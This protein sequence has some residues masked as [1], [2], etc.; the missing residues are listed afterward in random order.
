MSAF[1]GIDLGTS[2]V[3]AV[4][5]GAAGIKAQAEA[6]LS[7]SQPEQGWFEQNPEDWVD[8]T[9]RALNALRET[10]GPAWSEVRAIGLS[11]QMHGAV[12]L[13]H[14]ER[15]LRPAIL[16]SDGRAAAEAEYLA[17]SHMDL[18]ERA[19][20]RPT[21]SF[22][23]PKLLWL[24]EHEPVAMRA[25]RHLLFPKDY[26][27]LW[28]TGEH[29]TDPVDASGAWLFD[30]RTRSYCEPILEV[31]KVD[32]AVLP[33][34]REGPEVSG[35]LRPSVAAELGLPGGV[36]VAA[37]AGDAAAGGLG[38]GM[39]E[40]GDAFL[41]LGTSAQIFVTN[42]E[43]RPHIESMLHSFAHGLPGLWFQMAALLNGASPLRWWSEVCGQSPDRLLFEAKSVVLT[44]ADPLFLPYLAGERTPHNDPAPSAGFYP[45]S[46]GAD[47]ARLT[48]SLLEGVAFALADAMAALALA[49]SRPQKLVVTGGGTRSDLWMQMI[50][51]VLETPLVRLSGAT[52][53][54]ALG[55]A[56]LAEA[57]VV[58]IDRTDFS[59]PAVETVFLPE[60]Q[61]AA[62]APRLRAWRR[63]YRQVR[64]HAERSRQ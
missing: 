62:I 27:R 38:L 41:S 58:G 63:L 20:V 5:V 12:L 45:I 39:I 57:P 42:R 49:G 35:E 3:K 40:E 25:L 15:P 53:G 30:Q 16:W 56:R 55:A 60:R 19:G 52:V 44:P 14:D 36:V 32:R 8:A 9:R 59:K 33:V 17:R 29:C 51:T 50:A 21:A 23:A 28:L 1:I 18:A 4:L 22:V 34:V 46:A 13:G 43:Y 11:G 6:P 31:L 24:A 47:R 48:R 26:L 61:D 2:A 10:T 54:P 64:G 7:I 37:G